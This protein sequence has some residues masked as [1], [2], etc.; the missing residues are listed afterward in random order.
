MRGESG[1]GSDDWSHDSDHDSLTE[2]YDK[3]PQPDIEFAP[4]PAVP[5]GTP[6]FTPSVRSFEIPA[7]D[8]RLT[9][10]T[11]PPPAR[12][13]ERT[14]GMRRGP[15][16]L[17]KIAFAV[18]CVLLGVAIGGAIALGGSNSSS[19]AKPTPVAAPT[20]PVA[21]PIIAPVAPATPPIAPPQRVTVR[22]ETDPPGATATLIDNGKPQFLGTT[23]I[24]TDVDPSRSYEVVLTH[25]ERAPSI[26]RFDPARGNRVYA[27]LAPAR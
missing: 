23:P 2:V 26:E 22:I 8:D 5:R 18:G 19:R 9:I 25:A 6:R 21:Q 12:W 20:A 7:R 11:L 10:P 3:P 27:V 1:F 4:A 24:D 17:V 16:T 13:P 14:N 15:S